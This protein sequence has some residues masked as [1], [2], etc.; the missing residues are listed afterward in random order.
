MPT[1]EKEKQIAVLKERFEKANSFII[2]D[3]TG[4]NVA[5]LT[6]LRR[7]LKNANAEFRIAKNTLLKIAATESGNEQ[8]NDNFVGPTSMVF[9][10]DDPSA[11]AKIVY[12]FSKKTEIPKVKAYVLDNQLYSIEDFKRIAQLP[13]RE[14]VLALLMGAI[15]GPIYGFIMTLNGTVR[16]FIG[17]IDA[18]AESK[19]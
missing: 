18:M 10:F 17:L 19:K 3:H 12:E 5:D 7:D 13:S 14:E 15:S 4:I 8:I 9:G 1:K 6:V 16:N 11:P 2:T